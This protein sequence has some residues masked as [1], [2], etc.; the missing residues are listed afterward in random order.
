MTM[1]G[2]LVLFATTISLGV[3]V[4]CI[5]MLAALWLVMGSN[6]EAGLRHSAV[7]EAARLASR[8][9]VVAAT[10]DREMAA[11]TVLR[12][13]P[14]GT[15]VAGVEVRDATGK[16]IFTHPADFGAPPSFWSS[17]LG[18]AHVDRKAKAIGAVE[19]I[20]V[21]G[22]R[23][24]TVAVVVDRTG[25]DL[26]ERLLTIFI[27]LTV[28][29]WIVSAIFSAHFAGRF[30]RPFMAMQRFAAQIAG[31]HFEENLRLEGS[32]EV[33]SLGRS[34]GEMAIALGTRDQE[35][36]EQRV[37]LERSLRDLEDANIAVERARQDALDASAAKSEFLANMSHEIR[38]PLNGVIG[39]AELALDL[40]TSPDLRSYLETIRSSARGLS[41]IVNDI[42][43]LSKI[44]AGKL[45]IAP[46]RMSLEALLQE[47]LSIFALQAQS[48]AITIEASV[49]IDTPCEIV[50][51][52]V[53]IR[54]ILVNLLGN[55]MKF[56]SVGGVRLDVSSVTTFS[57]PGLQFVI[58]DTGIGMTEEQ[59]QR[60]FEAFA[61]A[62]TSTTR[63]FGGTGL[64]LTICR[65]L[66][67]LMGGQVWAESTPG[68]GSRFHV[69]LPYEPVAVVA[70]TSSCFRAAV[71]GPTRPSVE[72]L[73]AK[74]AAAKIPAEHVQKVEDLAH[75]LPD[76]VLVEADT[77]G[78][79]QVA[80]TLEGVAE[81][82]LVVV[83]S[84]LA[85][86]ALGG[87]R[88]TLRLPLFTGALRRIFDEAP[89]SADDKE[90]AEAEAP[91]TI[92]VAEDNRV[93]QMVI[94][95]LLQRSGHD[96]TIVGDGAAAC[97]ALTEG[98]FDLVLMDLQMPTM[99]GLTAART[100]RA[101]ENPSSRTPIYALTAHAMASAGEDCRDAG[102]DGWLTKPIDRAK[103]E[104]VLRSIR[105]GRSA[106][107]AGARARTSVASSIP[108]TVSTS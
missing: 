89:K 66:A 81:D 76:R 46:E 82:R 19:A 25:L 10:G 26:L 20:K 24:G 91:L 87:A 41:A 29:A 28:G 5:G 55:A 67:E 11:E 103:I 102:M 43:D 56:T 8:L 74:L 85:P 21:E 32:Q 92:L 69:E 84:N 80:G 104:D 79:L 30:V 39:M 86:T 7:T 14:Q 95:R 77:L 60:I 1:R 49:A 71:V 88:T 48:Q 9:D 107:G 4:L 12:S 47:T 15:P 78:I 58:T 44:E 27:A 13:L 54:Q 65:R 94:E 98:R 38:T 90:A 52:V 63:R 96:V 68:E 6:I 16:P 106:N 75:P 99:D 33:R 18:R 73:L 36:E 57:G 17:E 97:R 23:L 45:E 62:D 70:E 100:I 2:Q 22:L 34:L 61:Q 72:D 83:K 64:G 93:N 53:R 40:E 101:R 35:L 59:L 37:S 108:A 42:L 51:D 3:A 105:R 31:G 50:Q